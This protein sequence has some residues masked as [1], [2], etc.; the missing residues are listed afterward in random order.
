MPE[1]P[2]V[3]TVV[4]TLAPRLTGRTIAEARFFSKLVLRN[5]PEPELAGRR[6][7]EVTRH[8]K[9]ILARLDEG[10]L[11]IHLGMTGKLLFDAA[12]GPHTRAIFTL[13]NGVLL[14]DDIR[15]FGRITHSPGPPAHLNRLGPDA[16]SLSA[17]D[18][19]TR[20]RAR[21]ARVKSVLLNQAVLSGL[22]NIYVDECLFRAGIHPL[23]LAGRLSKPRLAALHAA[24]L[25]ILGHAIAKGG[26]SISDYVD[27]EGRRGSFQDAH[28]VY[29]KE[30][31][32]CPR[33]MTPIVKTVVAQ[34]GTH[35]CPRCQRR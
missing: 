31:A 24:M 15:Q 6:V 5:A 8:G 20:V 7:L 22:G 35:F 27:T 18:F 16:L 23:A 3:E 29:G 14:Y 9:N 26:S 1:L 33:C 11:T 17:A 25:D 32:P 2:E 30:G 19:A 12:P 21:S 10:H 34:R 28:Q 13:D 4:R